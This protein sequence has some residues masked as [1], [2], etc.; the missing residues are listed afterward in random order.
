MSQWL[1]EKGIGEERAIRIANGQIIETIIVDECR[2]LALGAVVR[3]QVASTTKGA[4]RARI[5][6]ETGGEVMLQ[7][8]P[9]G[10]TEG[11][12]VTGEIVREALSEASGV[13]HRLKLPIIKVCENAVLPRAAP[14][15]WNQLS[16]GDVPVKLCNNPVNDEFAQSGFFDLLE[17]VESGTVAFPGG[18]LII[19]PTPAMTVIDVDGDG[20]AL[21]LAK[22]AAIAIAHAISRLGIGGAIAIDFPTLQT[23]SDRSAVTEQFD[24]ALSDPWSFPHERT[25]INGFG[26]MQVV[27]KRQR[28]SLIE[29]AQLHPNHFAVMQLLRRAERSPVGGFCHLHVNEHAAKLIAA[30]PQWLTE[31]ERRT[32]RPA[33]VQ[34]DVSLE[35]H[36]F[37]IS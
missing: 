18:T 22:T 20:P 19:S 5:K 12:T 8:L 32:A 25:A 14:S 6:L 15:L 3:G 34:C 4:N 1:Y 13:H 33:T 21:S 30:N 27:R 23:K 17:E 11:T 16:A 10:L 24:A 29:R 28:A 37:A 31:L 35:T 9:K 26:L 36:Q 7:P 2:D